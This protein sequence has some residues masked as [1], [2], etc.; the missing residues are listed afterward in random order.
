[1]SITGLTAGF[2]V[3]S[4]AMHQ[5]PTGDWSRRVWCAA[6]GTRRRS[7]VADGPARL[8]DARRDL[9][10]ISRQ[11]TTLSTDSQIRRKTDQGH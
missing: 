10:V 1:M 3:H 6:H 7:V 2:P 5:A 9:D 4:P 8:Q 11:W